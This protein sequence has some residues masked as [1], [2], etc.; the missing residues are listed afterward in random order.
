VFRVKTLEDALTRKFA[1]EACDGIK[2]PADRLNHDIHGSAAYR[3]HL[4]PIL[5]RR[6]VH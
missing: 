2:V 4:I 5:A 6:A 3:A 1:P